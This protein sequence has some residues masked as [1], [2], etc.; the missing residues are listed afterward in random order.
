MTEKQK[1]ITVRELCSHL[2][3]LIENG[4]GDKTVELSVNYCNCDHIQPLGEV[5]DTDSE[6]IDWITLRGRKDD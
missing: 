4:K 3:H 2:L 1:R 6:L 5:W